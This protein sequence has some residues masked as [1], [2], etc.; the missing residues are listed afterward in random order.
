MLAIVAIFLLRAETSALYF[1]LI[2]T[3]YQAYEIVHIACINFVLSASSTHCDLCAFLCAF[4]TAIGDEVASFCQNKLLFYNYL[5]FVFS[6]LH[7]ICVRIRFYI[8][9]TCTYLN[10]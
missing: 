4:Y 7:R 5:I 2:L 9:N 8:C 6:N 3:R 10:C 1:L